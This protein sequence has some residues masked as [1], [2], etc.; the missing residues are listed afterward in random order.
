MNVIKNAGSVWAVEYNTLRSLMHEGMEV[1]EC[2]SRA[3][4]Q[5]RWYLQDVSR[6]R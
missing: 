4:E 2:S 3:S 6:I 1:K 5:A